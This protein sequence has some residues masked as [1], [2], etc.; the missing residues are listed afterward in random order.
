MFRRLFT[1]A[2][3]CACLA[4]PVMAL[5]ATA[6]NIAP[7]VSGFTVTSTSF[8]EGSKLGDRFVNDS[9]ECLSLGGNVSPALAWTAAPPETKSFAITV[10]DPDAR[11]GEGW[12]HWVVFNLPANAANIAEGAGVDSNAILPGSAVQ[13][14]ND[15]GETAYGGPCPPMGDASHRFVFTVWAL[16]VPS[17]NLNETASGAQVAKAMEGHVLAKG[18]ITGT[19]IRT[20][21][22]API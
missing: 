3:L 1:A 19:Y 16:D 14:R 5:P 15:F 10:Y 11:N 22:P 17:L 20:P 2:A 7:G 4:L 6:Q 12:W 18:I 9:G 21:P 8:D 13:A